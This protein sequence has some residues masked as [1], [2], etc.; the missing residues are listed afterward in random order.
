[1]RIQDAFHQLYYESNVWNGGSTAWLGVPVLKT[2]FDLWIYQ[3][4]IHRNKPDLIVECGTF[5]GGTAFYMAGIC[6]LIGT[7]KILAVDAV[8]R[9]GLPTHERINY[10]CGSSVGP[11]TIDYVRAAAAQ[12]QKVM[13]VLDS[14]HTKNHVLKE[15]D[16]YSTIVTRG[17]YLI[18]EDSNINGHPVIPNFGPGPAEAIDEFLKTNSNRFKID[19]T[20]EK[21]LLTFNPGG[22]LRCK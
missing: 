11:E 1:M 16:A 7:G 13:V 20:C 2:P 6:D 17:Q 4:I 22:Y 5:L 9:P 19:R 8:L 10:F 21:F 3:E 18:V 12:V 14:D 15:L